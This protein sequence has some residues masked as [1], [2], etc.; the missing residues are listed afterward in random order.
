MFERELVAALNECRLLL[1]STNEHQRDNGIEGV[2]KKF[3]GYVIENLEHSNRKPGES[4]GI[5]IWAIPGTSPFHIRSHL[6]FPGKTARGKG[7]IDGGKFPLSKTKP[8]KKQTN[9]KRKYLDL[10]KRPKNLG[11]G[12]R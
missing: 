1:C 6:I 4:R 12:N 8:K 5:N 3:G 7:H 9:W 11:K 10:L 2:I